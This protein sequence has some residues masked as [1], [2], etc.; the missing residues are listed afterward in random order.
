MKEHIPYVYRL[1]DKLT[2]MRYIGSRYAKVCCPEDLGV[3]YFTTSKTVN[4]LFRADPD[5]FEKQII[6]TGTKEY[7]IKVE[8]DLIELYDAVMS[9]EFYN[10][11]NAKAIHPDDIASGNKK[12]HSKRNE[13]GKSIVGVLSAAKCHADKDECGKSKVAVK[14]MTALHNRNRNNEGKSL[15]ALNALKYVDRSLDENG[16]MIIA[17]KAAKKLHSVKDENGKSMVMVKLHSEKDER[18][19][20]LNSV[21]AAGVIHS[22]K[23]EQGRSITAMKGHLQRD[24]NG[25][26]LL[27]LRTI[28]VA[29]N[30]IWK[31]L[32]CGKE[33][34][35]GP[36]GMHQKYSGHTGK[37]KV[38]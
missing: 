7:V 26:S 31:C 12:L 37:K 24:E 23:D 8:H 30:V 34:M 33:A 28:A 32:E 19:K 25:K 27:A 17:V 36:L 35:A 3:E 10:R 4:P 38:L 21:K 1:T 15:I 2:G 18:G 9:D 6:V 13:N 20:S 5:R 14:N 16:K 22:T 11:T 29:R